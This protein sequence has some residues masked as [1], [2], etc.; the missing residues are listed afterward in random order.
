MTLPEVGSVWH[1]A[2]RPMIEV[3]ITDVQEAADGVFVKGMTNWGNRLKFAVPAFLA[4]FKKGP[5]P[6]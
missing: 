1:R 6:R 3:T 2:E 4:S 5:I